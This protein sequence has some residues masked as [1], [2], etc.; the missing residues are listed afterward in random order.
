MT[1][2][3]GGLWSLNP[4]PRRWRVAVQAGLA[5]AI[6]LI[7]ATILGVP[8]AGLMVSMGAFTA[9]YY[10]ARPIHQRVRL[11]AVVG[12]GF[13]LSGALGVL[14]SGSALT[15]AG[16]LAIVGILAALL[17]QR[18]RVGPPGAMMFAL[19]YGACGHLTAPT[20]LGGAA[21][22]G[23]V[24]L[25][26]LALG[27][28]LAWAIVAVPLIVPSFRRRARAA[29]ALTANG[30]PAA[31]PNSAPW[32]AD[33]RI[34]AVR[35]VIAVLLGTGVAALSGTG[36]GYWVVCTALAVLNVGTSLSHA[37]NRGIQRLVGTLL[38]VGFY[39]LLTLWG[40]SGIVLAL[41]LG[42][43][44]F[45]IEMII[46]RNYALALVI[47]TPLALT[48]AGQAASADVGAL[49]T[50]RLVHTGLGGIV[51]LVAILLTLVRGARTR[52]AFPG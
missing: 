16:G 40:P 1:G 26:R 23:D 45:V 51:A 35:M 46:M 10:A 25:A 47:I 8:D 15:I 14:G 43:L 19:V 30:T 17:V 28:V 6:P 38:G 31:Q 27:I 13:F 32:S 11:L 21:L 42:T 48:I 49:V 7:G 41:V 34:V 37:L 36:H 29:E 33:E 3:A 18:L 4:S 52:P 12:T 39:L 9:I 22:P 2:R 5:M 20:A 50:E 24:L 44:Q